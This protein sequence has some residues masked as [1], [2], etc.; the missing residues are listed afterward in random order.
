[1]T[2]AVADVVPHDHLREAL[3][4]LVVDD[5]PETDPGRLRFCVHFPILALHYSRS[6]G[7]TYRQQIIEFQ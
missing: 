2:D 6:D 5:L 4:V 3:D 7:E 1:M